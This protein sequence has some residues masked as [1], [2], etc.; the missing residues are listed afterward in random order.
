MNFANSSMIIK[1]NKKLIR[2]RT[3]FAQ[4]KYQAENIQGK[5]NLLY[6]KKVP[7]DLLRVQ[8]EIRNEIEYDKR[9]RIK[10]YIVSVLAGSYVFIKYLI[11]HNFF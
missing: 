2:N 3:R 9:R 11:Y 5:V 1:E 10:V 8:K 7:E 6:P 4:T